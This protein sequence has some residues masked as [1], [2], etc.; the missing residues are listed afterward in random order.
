MTGALATYVA[1]PSTRDT[2]RGDVVIVPGLAVARYLRPTADRLAGLGIRCDVVDLPGFGDSENP[3]RPLGVAGFAAVVARHL[4]TRDGAPAVLVG[5]SSGTQV[6][7]LAAAERDV[8]VAG[9]V[10]AS[11]TVDPRYRRVPRLLLR[12][13]R[14]GGREPGSLTRLQRP[15]WRRAGARRIVTLLRSMLHHRLEDTV[16]GLDCPI[17]V[18]RAERDPLCTKEWA[19]QLAAGHRLVTVPG[20]PHA[21]P[22]LDPTG[23]AELIAGH[24]FDH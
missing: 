21:F 4:R 15:E 14:D 17:T 16:G 11:P 10:L 5:H 3:T 13:L 24:R 6:A 22:Y 19:A 23:F 12:W 1:E 8:R 18:V 9:L 2:C 20:L 7:A